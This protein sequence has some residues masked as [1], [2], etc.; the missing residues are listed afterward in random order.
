MLK[1]FLVEDEFVVREGIKNNINWE[2]AGYQFVGEASDGELAFPMIQ[3]LR[4]DIVITDIRMPFMDGLELSKLIRKDFPWMEIIILTGFS[5]FEYAKEAIKLGVAQYLLKPIN[6][7]ELLKEVGAVAAKIR[8][9]AKERELLEKYMQEVEE[10]SLINR[11]KLFAYLVSGTKSAR[12]LLEIAGTMEIDLSAV[13]Y[14]VIL[15][16]M[17]SQYHDSGEYSGSLVR[18]DEML[19]QLCA[20]DGCL[21]FDRNIE[22]KALILKADSVEEL[23]ERQSDM[24]SRLEKLF[25]EYPHVRYFG[26]IGSPASRLTEIPASFQAASRAFAHRYLINDSRFVSSEEAEN[27]NSVTSEKLDITQIDPKLFDK[28]RIRE[29]LK[30]GEKEET[31]YFVSEYFDNLGK[32]VLNSTLFR[33]YLSMDAYF[34]VVDFL[35]ELNLNREKIAPPGAGSKVLKNQK[36]A[37]DYICGIIEQAIELREEAASNKYRGVVARV[38]SYIRDN[39]AD[40]ELSLNTIASCLNF[41]PNHL[42]MVYSK[43]TGQPLI[44]YLTD[45]RM[46]KAKELLRCTGKR[47]GEICQEVGYK[48]PHYFSFLFKKTQGMTPTQYRSGKDE[49][50]E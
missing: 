14:N 6:G 13:C 4:P 17:Q 7:D 12:E 16:S 11:R 21:L 18:L 19:Q 39:Y 29:F 30:L 27:L 8:D 45:F 24:I 33:Q 43:E 32:D 28:S 23:Q 48:D 36:V 47:S 26:G 41:S 37:M 38:E 34:A 44:R 25:A 42:S 46:N 49:E 3:K 31:F 22:G 35:E 15:I 10:S 1:V 40:P 5:E 50:E 2:Q 9:R 20:Q